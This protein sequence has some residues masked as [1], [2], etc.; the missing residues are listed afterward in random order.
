MPFQ[1][2]ENLL[3]TTA[4]FVIFYLMFLIAKTVSA[5]IVFFNSITISTDKLITDKN[6]LMSSFMAKDTHSCL[7]LDKCDTVLLH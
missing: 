6:N 7:L 5:V 3:Y 4:W 1:T 2:I